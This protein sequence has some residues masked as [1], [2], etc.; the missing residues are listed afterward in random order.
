MKKSLRLSLIVVMLQ[1]VI[2]INVFATIWNVSNI[3]N[4]A[5]FKSL[6][7]AHDSE[8]VIAGDTLYVYGSTLNYDGEFICKKMLNIIGPGYFLN[9]NQETQANITPAKIGIIEF[10]PG[11]E[12]SSISGMS[13]SKLYIYCNNITIKRNNILISSND[14]YGINLVREGEIQN[15]I[16]V[17]NFI[18]ARNGIHFASAS[19]H[20]MI[21]NNII[22][23]VGHTI[24][25]HSNDYAIIK[26]N[27]LYGNMRVY[28][29]TFYNNI[30]SGG[31]TVDLVDSDVQYNLDYGTKF[32]TI[33]GNMVNVDMST[34]F[35]GQG[36]EDGKWQ[37]AENSPA[38]NAG[39]NGVDCGAFDGTDPYI[40]SGIPMLPSI[41]YLNVPAIAS[42]ISGLPVHIKIKSRN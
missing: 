14:Q 15:I 35:I 8:K 33:N 24:Y 26:N 41:Y 7:A 5:N 17:Q 38:K 29:S 36:S 23:S 13:I 40:L 22:K 18:N 32:G 4:S 16:I 2:T 10:S 27:V 1:T 6:M 30:R 28:N 3:D 34:V 42:E 39:D 37:L 20:I 9:E 11:S 12:G 25:M 21:F 19:N 31:G